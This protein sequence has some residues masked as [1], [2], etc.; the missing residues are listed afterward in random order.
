MVRMQP[1]NAGFTFERLDKFIWRSFLLWR[2]RLFEMFLPQ[3]CSLD[4]NML[5]RWPILLRRKAVKTVSCAI[6]NLSQHGH[7]RRLKACLNCYFSFVLWS[8]LCL[9]FAVEAFTKDP[10][11]TYSFCTFFCGC[12]LELDCLKAWRKLSKRFLDHQISKWWYPGNWHSSTS[13]SS[14]LHV[15]LTRISLCIQAKFHELAPE[16]IILQMQLLHF[17]HWILARPPRVHRWRFSL[18]RRFRWRM[19]RLFFPVSCSAR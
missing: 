7:D 6:C 2:N 4:F 16:L 12:N 13:W 11:L 15:R 5:W 10:I 19:L 18:F 9:S 17:V 8:A 1:H 14:W 3:F